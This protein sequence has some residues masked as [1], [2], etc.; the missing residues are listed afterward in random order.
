MLNIKSSFILKII[1][2]HLINNKKLEI[3]IYNKQLQDILGININDYKNVN[4]RYKI[5][6][7]NGKGKE[8]IL[9]TNTLFFEGE[10]L[11]G[12]RNGKGIEYYESGEI[13]SVVEY[14]NGKKNGKGKEYNKK[15]KLI[16]EGDYLNGT[17]N[18]KGK[19]YYNNGKLKFEGEYINGKK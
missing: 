4:K 17:K 5:G 13:K 2:S 14:L 15:G 1:F 7:K 3:I 10:Y 19:D 9:G 11:N 18:G 8:Y 12:K 6:G 16:Y